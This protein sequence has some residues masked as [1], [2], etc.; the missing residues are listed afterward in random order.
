MNDNLLA[1]LERLERQN[2]T[3]KLAALSLLVVLAGGAAMQKP[4]DVQPTRTLTVQRLVLVDAQGNHRALLSSDK[5]G[6]FL[7]FTGNAGTVR[8]GL[9]GAEARLD[10]FDA[11]KNGWR[12][13]LRREVEVVPA[14]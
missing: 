1:R 9:D 5:E 13:W 4:S 14:R 3:W 11:S 2:R 7:V 8:L 10:T 6:A 12:N